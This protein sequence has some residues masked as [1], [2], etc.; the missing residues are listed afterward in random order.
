VQSIAPGS[1]CA[2]TQVIG[3]FQSAIGDI[4]TPA[5]AGTPCSLATMGTITGTLDSN[6]DQFGFSVASLGQPIDKTSKDDNFRGAF[7]GPDGTMYVAKGSGSNGVNTV[8]QV[9]ATA[10]FANG[11]T[12][13]Q[14]APITIVPGFPTSLAANIASPLTGT[15]TNTVFPFNMW[16]P[17]SAPTLMFVS[18]EG[19]G[20]VGD[21]A[22]GSGGL[23]VYQNQGGTW[24]ALERLTAGLNLGVPYTVT[25]TAGTYGTAGASYTTTAQGLHNITGQTNSDGSFTIFATTATLA[26]SIAGGFDDGAA[27]NQLVKITIS[28]SG[29]TVTTGGFTVME[30]APFG[31]VVRGVAIVPG[32]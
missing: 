13:P 10:V 22:S 12:L 11:G 5:P 19:D 28:V 20:V 15:Q 16:I 9:G 30:T 24:H 23:W 31:Q 29:A 17:A 14:N 4:Y 8:Y 1:T 6:G 18:D 26:T 2:F 25:D 7:V 32:T 21:Q 3:A 27:S